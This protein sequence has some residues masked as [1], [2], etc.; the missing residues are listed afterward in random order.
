[1]KGM[2]VLVKV[3][4]ALRDF[5]LFTNNGS[6]LLVPSKGDWMWLAIK[7][8]LVTRAESCEVKQSDCYIRIKLLDSHGKTY[9]KSPKVVYDD[10]Y[11]RIKPDSAHFIRINTSYRCYLSEKGHSVIHRLLNRQF[12]FHFH[13][14]MFAYLTA[15]PETEQKKAMLAYLDKFNISESKITEDMLIKSWNRSQEKVLLK[16]GVLFTPLMR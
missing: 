13:T 4:P 9:A 11:R 3:N 14:F 5:I 10:N 7:Q 6:D 16:K 2:I 1:M 8:Q 15:N 12:K